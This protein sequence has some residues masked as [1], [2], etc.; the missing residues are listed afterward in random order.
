MLHQIK[1]R[2]LGSLCIIRIAVHRCANQIKSDLCGMKT[3]FITGTVC[4][5]KLIRI[6]GAYFCEELVQSLSIRSDAARTVRGN[7]IHAALH[8]RVNFPHGRRDI[9]V[10]VSVNFL[11]NADHRKIYRFL[12]FHNICD[13]VS[14]D[15]DRAAL[16]GRICHSGHNVRT[17]QRFFL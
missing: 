6:F 15:A 8:K 2:K 12:N 3:F 10:T 11:N 14:S 13:G 1:I 5:K 17:V 16:F 4:H 9:Y 7:N